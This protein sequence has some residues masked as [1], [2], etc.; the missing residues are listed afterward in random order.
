MIA[1]IVQLIRI[2]RGKS[3][4]PFA[5]CIIMY[6]QLTPWVHAV[7]F[8]LFYTADVLTSCIQLFKDLM[9]IIT[10]THCPDFVLFM[11]VCIPTLIRMI[12]CIKRIRENNKFYPHGAN[13]L[14]YVSAIFPAVLVFHAVL[15]NNAAYT[16][17]YI[18]KYI[19]QGY[20]LYWDIIEDWA[21]L[22][23]G[24]GA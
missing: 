12:Q 2:A 7:T 16:T 23:G 3:Q 17:F 5:L 9:A 1:L 24:S 13:A 19:E 11:V 4:I 22:H 15:E 18:T 10:N 8:P 20:K 21:L 14:K 6:K